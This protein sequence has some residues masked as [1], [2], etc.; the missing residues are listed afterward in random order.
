MKDDGR[1]ILLASIHINRSHR[2]GYGGRRADK[3]Y[4]DSVN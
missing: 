3:I 1:N 2:E 4:E